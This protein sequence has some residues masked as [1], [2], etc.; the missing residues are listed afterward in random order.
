[1]APLPG[2]LKH[3]FLSRRA[4][5]PKLRPKA[6]NSAALGRRDVIRSHVSLGWLA[7]LGGRLLVSISVGREG[8]A[9]DDRFFFSPHP[10]RPR[11]ATISP[12][13]PSHKEGGRLEGETRVG[14]GG[15]L[16][17]GGSADP[18]RRGPRVGGA[19]GSRASPPPTRVLTAGSLGSPRGSSGFGEHSGSAGESLGK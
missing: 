2:T 17:A 15:D 6:E 16:A 12:P 4:H 18:W 9:T 11:E 7:G 3:T 1:M 5:S 19:R 14:R 10:S 13:S 8:G